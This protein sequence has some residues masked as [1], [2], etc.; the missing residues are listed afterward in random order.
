MH[1][2]LTARLIRDIGLD[3]TVGRDDQYDIG[4]LPLLEY[5]LGQ[6]WAKRKDEEIGLG[7][8]AGLEQALEDAPT[9]STNSWRRHRRRPRSACS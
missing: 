9:S 2:D 5:A 3:V 6:A 1:P 7:Q 8:Y 4:K